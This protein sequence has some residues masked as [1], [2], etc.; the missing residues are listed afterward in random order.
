[1]SRV[2]AKSPYLTFMAIT[3]TPILTAIPTGQE[4]V[5]PCIYMLDCAFLYILVQQPCFVSFSI[6]SISHLGACKNTCRFHAPF[7]TYIA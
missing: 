6:Q 2:Q 5:V 1:V 7:R 4:D 3:I